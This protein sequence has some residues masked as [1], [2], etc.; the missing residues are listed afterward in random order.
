MH[1]PHFAAAV[2][3][4]LRV[5]SIALALF[6]W[7]GPA[8]AW[9]EQSV[10]GHETRLEVQDRG[11]VEVR[12]QLVLALRGGPLEVLEIEGIGEDVELLPDAKVTRVTQANAAGIPLRL[13]QTEGGALRIEVLGGHGL[14]GGTYRF[15][16]AYRLDAIKKRL[17]VAEGD[18][19]LLTWVGPRLHGGVDSAK[20]IVS[21]PHA[22]TPPELP[23]TPERAARGV[24]LGQV[25]VGTARDEIELLRTHVAV[26]EPAVW[27]VG[28][29]R[30]AVPGALAADPLEPPGLSTSRRQLRHS[31]PSALGL[32]LT[33]G[34]ALLVFWLVWR[35]ERAVA[36]IAERTDSRARP[37][38]PSPAW[39]RGLLCASLAGGFVSLT[40]LYRVGLAMLL[41]LCL[42]VLTVHFPPVRR[43]TPRGPG[44]W[45]P[46]AAETLAPP[47]WPLFVRS[48]D[49]S[50][51]PGFALALLLVLSGVFVA[52]F[53]L[54]HDSTQALMSLTFVLLLAP[55]L[56]TGRL[57]DFP[58]SPAE[59]ALSWLRLLRATRLGPI[60]ALELW[61]RQTDDSRGPA[62]VDEVR[63]RIVLGEPPAGLRALEVAFEEG[64]GNY[65]SPC[66]VVRVI[67]DSAAH[68][69]L[70]SGIAW[71]RG[72]QSEEKTAI[73]HPRAPTRG[74]LLRLL[75][76]VVAHLRRDTTAPQS[77]SP[78]RD[79][80]V[81]RSSSSSDS[82][83]NRNIPLSAAM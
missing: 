16:F 31:G 70:P 83:R 5:L 26:G 2:G 75:R 39:L 72:R 64:P 46:L 53:R 34:L 62:G 49:S 82:A 51:L 40:L 18:G 27:Q 71:T 23:E 43:K 7:A 42:A 48:H 68:V 44:T 81:R 22:P 59:Q 35:K 41:G 14:R 73:L 69:R 58:R 11:W 29:D 79:Q 45:V 78:S 33:I 60:R 47:A 74:Q 21:V 15:D 80:N 54:P 76:S 6:C 63:V 66:L 38:V 67:E 57:T 56:S 65:V 1:W 52:Y 28:L 3:R 25:L 36:I 24:L 9:I 32:G 55:L 50:T 61:G 30:A 4:T 77:G 37:L 20:V 8:C 10:V 13:A 17:L 12:H 19:A